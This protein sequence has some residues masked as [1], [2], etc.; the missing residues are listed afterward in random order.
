MKRIRDL[1]EGLLDNPNFI[2]PS[3]AAAVRGRRKEIQ[4]EKD[5]QLRAECHANGSCSECGNSITQCECG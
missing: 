3:V 1:V 2:H 4:N 5:A